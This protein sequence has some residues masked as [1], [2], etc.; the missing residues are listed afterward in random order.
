MRMHDGADQAE[1]QPE[2]RLVP[3][4]VAAVEPGPDALELVGGN[5]DPGIPDP[6]DDVAIVPRRA[7]LYPP[8]L[9]CVFDRVVDQVRQHLTETAAV[10]HHLEAPPDGF[11]QGHA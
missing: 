3:A 6:D 1:A 9:R 4:A 8:A 7:D 2:A 11:L 10:G 5:A